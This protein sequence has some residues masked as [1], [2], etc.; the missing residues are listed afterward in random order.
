MELAALG[1]ATIDGLRDD[2]FEIR[3]GLAY[4]MNVMSRVA[5]E[6]MLRELGKSAERMNASVQ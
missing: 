5:P 1:A 4:V 3:P 6:L 2:R